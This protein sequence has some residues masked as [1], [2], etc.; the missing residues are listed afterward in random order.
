MLNFRC[1]G[2]KGAM[3]NQR[4]FRGLKKG[5]AHEAKLK[6]RFIH[7]TKTEKGFDFLNKF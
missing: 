6:N 5:F 3:L 2:K 1:T 7:S 4:M